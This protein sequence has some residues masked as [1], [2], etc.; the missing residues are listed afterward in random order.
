MVKHAAFEN[1]AIQGCCFY[2]IPFQFSENMVCKYT[3]KVDSGAYGEA[4]LGAALVA[5]Q[6]GPS[7][8]TVARQYNI[9]PKTLRW[10]RDRHMRAPGAVHVGGRNVTVLPHQFEEQLVRYTQIME[11]QMYA[12]MTTDVRLLAYELAERQNLQHPFGRNT[13]MAGKDWLRSFMTRHPTL[14]IRVPIGTSLAC[15]NGFNWAAVNGFFHKFQQTLTGGNFNV[16]NIWNCGETGFSNVVEPG[17]KV[18]G[19][20]DLLQVGS[21]ARMWQLYAVWVRQETLSRRCSFSPGN[22]WWLH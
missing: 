17:T 10:H 11:S 12:L 18:S 15:I 19:R 20:L 3:R 14:S 7:V 5:I 21:V 1:C 8:K 9:P 22:V 13:Q 4:A 2:A 6:Q 16:T